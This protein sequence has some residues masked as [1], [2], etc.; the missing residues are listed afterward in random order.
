MYHGADRRKV[1]DRR[2]GERRKFDRDSME[3]GEE[4]VA[5]GRL[6]R[7]RPKDNRRRIRRESGGRRELDH[8]WED[9]VEEDDIE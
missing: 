6:G 4:G 7:E 3:D 9:D 8:V 1:S 5:R 2:K